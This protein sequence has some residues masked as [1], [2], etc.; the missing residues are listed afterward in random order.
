MMPVTFYEVRS[1]DGVLAAIHKR[2]DRADG[3]KD[4]F[5]LEPEGKLGLG[6][7]PTSADD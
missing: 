7:R 3:G 6:G 5:W 2:V 4:V 1:R